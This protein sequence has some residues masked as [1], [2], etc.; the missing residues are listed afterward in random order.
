VAE[1]VC[2]DCI[3]EGVTRARPTPHGGPRSPRCV[4]HHRARRKNQRD[5][6]HARRTEA[7]YGITTE[8]YWSL[9]D[10]QG[11]RCFI[12]QRA[13]GHRK[14]LAVDHEHHRVGCEH[15]PETGCPL[16]VRALLCGPC[17]QLIGRWGVTALT[18]AITV[19]TD[20][21]AQRVLHG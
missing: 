19:L 13:T 12:C 6:S 21:P 4:T 15:A 1:V 2:K 3:A 18:R 7:T 17:N 14:R 8:Q 11:C 10:A 9:Y 5:R 20:P 16:C